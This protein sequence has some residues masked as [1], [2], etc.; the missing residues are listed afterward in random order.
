VDEYDEFFALCDKHDFIG[1][2]ITDTRGAMFD[3]DEEVIRKCGM[4]RERGVELV[5]SP[6]SGENYS[7]IIH[8]MTVHAIVEGKSRGVDML[9]RNIADMMRSIELGYRGSSSTMRA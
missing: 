5:M 3:T 1:N 6:G 4:C 9:V 8:Q 2:K 7:D